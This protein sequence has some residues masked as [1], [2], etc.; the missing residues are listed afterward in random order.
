[1]RSRSRTGRWRCRGRAENAHGIEQPVAVTLTI[2]DDDGAEAVTAV[3]LPEAARAM[4][5]S[6]AGAVRRRLESA[7]AAGPPEMASLTALL[8]EH[9]PSV[10]DDS[11][12]WKKTLAARRSRCR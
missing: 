9:G 4:A 5:D 1:M 6:R 2:R 7:D 12:D 11:L 3:L 10:Q 8:A